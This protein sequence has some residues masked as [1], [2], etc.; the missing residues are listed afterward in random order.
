MRTCAGVDLCSTPHCRVTLEQEYKSK[1]SESLLAMNTDAK[2]LE[3]LTAKNEELQDKLIA[4]QRELRDA[5][6]D[7]KQLQVYMKQVRVRRQHL[8]LI[9]RG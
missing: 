9:G 2:L 5:E 7:A 3:E 1:Y 6:K 8:P 4:K